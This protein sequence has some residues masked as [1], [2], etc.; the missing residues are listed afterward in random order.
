MQDSSNAAV[1]SEN[2]LLVR[3]MTFDQ[4]LILAVAVTGLVVSFLLQV[5]A[6]DSASVYIRF[7]DAK[8]PG[9]CFS[10]SFFDQECPGCGITRSIVCLSQG[11]LTRSLRFN[12]AGIFLY[13]YALGYIA[14]SLTRSKIP[15]H[16]FLHSREAWASFVWI[17]TTLVLLQWGIRIT[18]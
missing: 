10:K 7:V 3:K 8:I 9:M 16:H 1:G 15:V 2:R 13:V 4:W 11:E 5:K 17:S 18:I 6:D 12:V 14:F